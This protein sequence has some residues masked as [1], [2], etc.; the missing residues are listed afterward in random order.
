LPRKVAIWSVQSSG[1][2]RRI[3]LAI[4]GEASSIAD[5]RADCSRLT[6]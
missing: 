6:R 2:S 1:I 5:G 4:A 3:V